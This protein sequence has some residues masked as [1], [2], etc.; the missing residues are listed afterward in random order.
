MLESHTSAILKIQLPPSFPENLGVL[1]PLLSSSKLVNS[2]PSKIS[3]NQANFS[4]MEMINVWLQGVKDL[5]NGIFD[6]SS[7]FGKAISNQT[8][9]NQMLHQL[10]LVMDHSRELTGEHEDFQEET[11]QLNEGI[12]IVRENM[13]ILREKGNELH[14]FIQS[15]PLEKMILFVQEYKSVDKQLQIIAKYYFNLIYS[16]TEKVSIDQEISTKKIMDAYLGLPVYVLSDAKKKAWLSMAQQLNTLKLN[17]SESYTIQEYLHKATLLIQLSMNL[18]IDNSRYKVLSSFSKNARHYQ[19]EGLVVD[20]VAL[21]EELSVNIV[22][23]QCTN[24]Q[25]EHTLVNI[26]IRTLPS[27]QTP[28]LLRLHNVILSRLE[29]KELTYKSLIEHCILK[30][31][32]NYSNFKF[33][34]NF[35]MAPL[36]NVNLKVSKMGCFDSI[37]A[38]EYE[39]NG[40]SFVALTSDEYSE[41]FSYSATVIFIRVDKWSDATDTVPV[42]INNRAQ[43]LNELIPIISQAMEPYLNNSSEIFIR[44][45]LFYDELNVDVSKS[46]KW[47][48]DN[49]FKPFKGNMEKTSVYGVSFHLNLRQE[50]TLNYKK[51]NISDELN[52][53]P[54]FGELL[55]SVLVPNHIELD[56]LGLQPKHLFSEYLIADMTDI[57]TSKLNYLSNYTLSSD[58][59]AKQDIDEESGSEGEFSVAY[60]CF[61]LI[62]SKSTTTGYRA[63]IQVLVKTGETFSVVG[64]PEKET[65]TKDQLE[66]TI[67]LNVGYAVY[68][69]IDAENQNESEESDF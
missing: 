23:A 12:R 46:L 62:I 61:A 58:S 64:S 34:R 37:L 25:S 26:L 13:E 63:F 42:I 57:P 14:A 54:S 48:E 8:S 39:N 45:H 22:K 56:N 31:E 66:R 47:Y 32:D 2:W 15:I 17:N 41:I 50:F 35:T 30:I 29:E 10:A 19:V 24:F 1:I 18:S 60:E 21:N 33:I 40:Y 44:T 11:D 36:R 4:Q 5:S 38:E 51:F 67:G 20:S 65:R 7:S 59:L 3:G 52:I 16:E 28:Y 27:Q 9:L 49:A 68:R 43:T 55:H 6:L 53:K 69:R